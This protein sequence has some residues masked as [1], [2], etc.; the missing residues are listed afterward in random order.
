MGCL[1]GGRVYPCFGCRGFSFLPSNASSISIRS[2][3]VFLDPEKCQAIDMPI[4]PVI[5]SP[6]ALEIVAKTW[7]HLE[8][9]TSVTHVPSLWNREEPIH[10]GQGLS[11]LP[12][13][14]HQIALEPKTQETEYISP[15]PD[16]APNGAISINGNTTNGHLA[17]LHS[18]QKSSPSPK[19]GWCPGWWQLLHFGT[20]NTLSGKRRSGSRPRRTRLRRTSGRLAVRPSGALPNRGGD[21]RINGTLPRLARGHD[22]GRCRGWRA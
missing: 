6:S 12:K 9:I 4:L 15:R 10:L 3:L 16:L 20:P 19:Q 17:S 2:G 21:S 8:A 22:L 7:I 14:S 13:M 11:N 18:P 5:A 1:D